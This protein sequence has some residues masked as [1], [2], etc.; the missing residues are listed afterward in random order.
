M[1]DS[2]T[3]RFTRMDE[4]TREEYQLLDRIYKKLDLGLADNVLQYNASMDVAMPEVLRRLHAAPAD[5]TR[6]A[7]RSLDG[8]WW[9]T[10]VFGVDEEEWRTRAEAG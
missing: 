2:A 3:V 6:A 7:M 10:V 4:G 1:F 5:V 9:D 8:R